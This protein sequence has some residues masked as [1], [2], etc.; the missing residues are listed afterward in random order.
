[1]SYSGDLAKGWS[2]PVSIWNLPRL[3]NG[4]DYAFHA[5]PHYDETG[6]VVPLMWTKFAPPSTFVISMANATFA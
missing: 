5:L 3:D 2:T 6:R 1:M 4:Y